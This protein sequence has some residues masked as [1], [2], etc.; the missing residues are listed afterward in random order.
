MKFLV[1]LPLFATLLVS[2]CGEKAT[3]PGEAP[4][5]LSDADIERIL[6]EAIERDSIEEREGLLFH[7]NKPYSGWVKTMYDSGQV[8]GLG[9]LKDDKLGPLTMWCEN[10][11]K[12]SETTF[13]DGQSNV[14]GPAN[15]WHEN[16]K[17]QAEEIWEDH[18]L[19]SAKYWN[20]KGEEVE[21]AEE[22]HE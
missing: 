16:G 4:E 19:I 5:S 15:F 2:G 22:T 20:N 7:G 21:T 13:Q 6:K 9:R 12:R 8:E 11:Q 1:L 3:I 10:G 18:E 14:N 17:K